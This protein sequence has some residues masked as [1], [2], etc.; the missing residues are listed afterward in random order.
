MIT[1]ADCQQQDQEFQS[2]FYH[3]ESYNTHFS[4]PKI[5]MIT[6]V[7]ETTRQQVKLEDVRNNPELQ[8][9]VKKH[10]RERKA[11]RPF[12]N[13][14]TAIFDG[15]KA[16]K[17]F[18]NGKMHVTGCTKVSYGYELVQRFGKAMQWADYAI[19][20]VKI[21]TFNTCV[22]LASNTLIDLSVFHDI[23]NK[24]KIMNRYTPDTYQGLVIKVFYKDTTKKISILCFY[25]GNFIITGVSL[26]EHLAYGFQFLHTIMNDVYRDIAL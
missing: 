14:V 24:K 3:F 12:L 18:C 2:A 21:L 13:C 20:N 4:S 1:H 8:I 19:K 11:Y 17:V 10:Q 5:C 6:L 22:K 16:I 7:F 26:P 23:L 15:K 9:R 25:T